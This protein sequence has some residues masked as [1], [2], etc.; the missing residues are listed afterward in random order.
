MEISRR[1]L[2][3]LLVIV[4]GLTGYC[5][6]GL[7]PPEV[8]TVNT[9]QYVSL[10]PE[11]ITEVVIKEQYYTQLRDFNSEL[12]FTEWLKVQN[13]SVDGWNCQDYTKW[14]IQRGADDGYFVYYM[15]VLSGTY[16]A[17][18]PGAFPIIGNHAI[19]WV[20]AGDVRIYV[21]TTNGKILSPYR[22]SA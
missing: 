4:V 17:L 22:W 16:E 14:L 21:D 13:T 5:F 1:F 15:S 9:T 12:E 6:G 20:V 3:A 11:V 2:Y 18:F 8:I 10:P 19:N 7:T